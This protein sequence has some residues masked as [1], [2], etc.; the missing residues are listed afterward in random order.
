MTTEDAYRDLDA[1]DLRILAADSPSRERRAVA[2]QMLAKREE[3]E[4]SA[5]LNNAR[6]LIRAA[7][8][9]AVQFL[10]EPPTDMGDADIARVEAAAM[11]LNCAGADLLF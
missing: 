8:T 10:A 1:E 9:A 6:A 4:R 3:S 11:D 2:A 7:V 5:R